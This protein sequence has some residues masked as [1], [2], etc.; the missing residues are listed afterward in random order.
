MQG[1]PSIAVVYATR[2]RAGVLAES[3]RLVRHQTMQP[4]L[5]LISCVAPSDAPDTSDDVRTRVILSRPGLTFQ[6]NAA[7]E[8]LP[9]SIDVV[10]FFD[11]DF[12]PHEDWLATAVAAFTARPELVGVT[13]RLLADGIHDGGLTVEE[14]LRL[15]ETPGSPSDIRGDEPYSPYGCNM[16]FAMRHIEG[17]RFDERLVLYGWQEDRDF[18]SLAAR[19]GLL[20]R[21]ENALG[22]HL[23]VR[24]ARVPGRKLGY[25]Q[26]VNPLYLVRKGTMRP[27]EA[28]G[29]IGRNFGRNL[30]RSLRPEPWIDRRGRLAGNMFGLLDVCRGRLRPERAEDF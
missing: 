18:G 26:I 10:A 19:R 20:L 5:V 21:L 1:A 12:L 14:G 23:G 24:S 7:L 16:A 25:S 22:V 9:S 11:D 30:L 15:L 6:R 2:G 13:G 29:H 3:L 8:A 17:L 28:A 27:G 4:D